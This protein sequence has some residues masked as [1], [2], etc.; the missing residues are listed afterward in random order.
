MGG[1]TPWRGGG[2]KGT[3]VQSGRPF[4]IRAAASSLRAPVRVVDGNYKLLS[5]TSQWWVGME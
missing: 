1:K 5:G 2:V 4:R 3:M